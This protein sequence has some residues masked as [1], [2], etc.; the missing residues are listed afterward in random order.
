M[1]EFTTEASTLPD[2]GSEEH[3]LRFGIWDYGLFIGMLAIS[4]LIGVYFGFMSKKKQD[5]TEEYLLGGKKM[6]IFP[7]S[8]SLIASHISG[9]TILG[10]PT[11]IYAYG[12]QYW[13]IVICA[14][15][16]LLSIIYIFLPVFH[17][18]Q[19]T[20]CFSYLEKRFDRKVRVVASF[21]F[22]LNVML[23]VPAVIYVPAL[24]F[25]QVTGVNLHLITPIIC[26]ICIF[27]TTVGGL[28]AVVYTDALQFIMMVGATLLVMFLGIGLT[29]GFSGVWETAQRGGR[30]IFF[31]MDPNPRLGSSF[32]TVTLGL[33]VTWISLL[34]VTQSS[35]QRFLSMPDMKSAR[36][37]VWV[38]TLGMIFI[39]SCCIFVGLI[40][41]AKY[42]TCDPYTKGTVSK[43]DQILPYFI[44]DVGAKIPGLPGI[45]IAGIFSAALSSMSSSLNT[46]AGT[47]YEDFFRHRYPKASEKQASNRMKM[48]V[49]IL[50]II[51]LACVFVVERMGTVFYLTLSL[52]GICAGA[53]LGIF[54]MGMLLRKANTKGIISGTIVSLVIVSVIVIGAQ[55]AKRPSPL[56]LR[57]DGCPGMNVTIP[58]TQASILPE[59]DFPAIFLIS[60][61]YYS[62]LGFIIILLVGY[63][64]SLLTGGNEIQDERLLCHFVRSREFRERQKTEEAHYAK[65]GQTLKELEAN[66]KI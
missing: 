21:M 40:I 47:I 38:F 35:V 36:K 53:L 62:L 15:L 37:S 12:T 23:F 34:G 66:G 8:C 49:V 60:P 13:M 52:N 27:Y 22:A 46:L 17:D 42:E 54:G 61:M 59:D 57:V 32:W 55:F 65:I 16:T 5:N 10:V 51:Q 63:T 33:S 20:S 7:V 41:Y 30:L 2:F 44:M 45:F 19:L 24:A 39:K 64:V 9:S 56:P 48:I 14:F 3:I 1:A 18:L 58:A 11:Q 28:K 29:G 43:L 4:A 6:S 50:G 26:A 31:E 25:N